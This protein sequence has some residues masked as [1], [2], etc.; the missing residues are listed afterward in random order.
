MKRYWKLVTLTTLIVVI[1]GTLL[2]QKSLATSDF[3]EFVIKHQSGDQEEVK[4]LI[5]SGDYVLDEATYMY[6]EISDEGTSYR[7]NESSYL[8]L[9]KED[10]LQPEMKHL[11][12]N[13]RSF[14]RGKHEEQIHSF[15]EDQHV[16][17]YVD[18][19]SEYLSTGVHQWS[20][21]FGIEVLDKETKN[22]TKF[23]LA[24]PEVEKYDYLNIQAV[25][26]IN[27]ELKIM[28]VNN[29]IN[30]NGQF[31]RD[32]IHIYT[33]DL[34]TQKIVSD[35]AIDVT[36]TELASNQWHSMYG[37]HKGG[38]IGPNKYFVF[39]SEKNEEIVLE[40]H[41]DYQ[42]VDSQLIV[43]NL[44]TSEQESIELPKEYGAE[45]YPELLS[46]SIVYFSKSEDH[47]IEVVGYDLE[48][49]QIETKQ[50]FDLLEDEG[51]SFTQFLFMND[52]IYIVQ[53]LYEGKADSMIMIGDIQTGDILY[54]GIVELAASNKDQQMKKMHINGM[55]VEKE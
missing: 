3:P 48:S 16:L 52:K 4:P 51:D 36:T 13:Y 32:E 2:I 44:E 45:V 55:R 10:Y 53:Q 42:M 20:Y 25:Q 43:Y 23:D 12:K 26:L 46:G 15:F 50:T 19:K 47:E 31:S 6:T 41:Y 39:I 17:A 33:V 9:L 40:D 14:M 11:I 30:N 18:L 29:F 28:T 37:V 34:D 8:Y 27:D 21:T 5:I 1:I 54:E 24:I 38:D 49:G 7:N 22:K 35:E